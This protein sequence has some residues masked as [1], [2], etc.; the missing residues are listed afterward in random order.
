MQ[1]V[2]LVI[3]L[4]GYKRPL[5]AKW[6]R[7]SSQPVSNVAFFHIWQCLSG[8]FFH[9]NTPCGSCPPGW[10]GASPRG[11]KLPLGCHRHKLAAIITAV[12]LILSL[13]QCFPIRSSRTH[14]RFMFLL[15]LSSS[16]LSVGPQGSDWEM[17]G[18]E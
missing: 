9:I 6:P 11:S 15:L 13:E 10:V 17:N 5:Q 2:A 12:I 8:M 4:G 18:S 7:S 14:S 16:G 1:C 3:E